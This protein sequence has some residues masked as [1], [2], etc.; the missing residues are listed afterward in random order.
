M[1]RPVLPEAQRIL[2]A[3]TSK[4][5]TI[6]PCTHSGLAAGKS[7]LFT[8]GT[9]VKSC[10][11]ARVELSHKRELKEQQQGRRASNAR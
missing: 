8:T 7:F 10:I 5:W 9:I 2:S 6:S 1:P 4:A 3:G 11:T